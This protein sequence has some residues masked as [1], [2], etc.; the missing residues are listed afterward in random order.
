MLKKNFLAI[1]LVA[2]GI[3]AAF[4][5]AQAEQVDGLVSGLTGGLTIPS[6]GTDAGTLNMFVNPGGLGDALI[7]GYYNAR[8]SW[9]FIRVVN[10]S[11]TL[12]IGAKVRFREGKNSN[13][14]LDFAICLSAGDEWSAWLLDDGNAANPATLYWYDSDTPS[15]PDPN[16]DNVVTN[17]F[18]TAIALKYAPNAVSSVTADDTK[19]GYLEII[20]SNAWTD[21]PGTPFIDTPDRCNDVLGINPRKGTGSAYQYETTGNHYDAP[22]VLFG[23]LYI[24]QLSSSYPIGTYAYNA[25]AIANLMRSPMTVS[26]LSDSSPRLDD[27][28][29][30][31]GSGTGIDEVN[32][33]LTKAVEYATYDLETWLTGKTTIINTFPTKKLSL[34]HMRNAAYLATL[35]GDSG[36]FNDL[37]MVCADGTIGTSDGAGVGLEACVT[38]ALTAY[39]PTNERCEEVAITIWDDAEH[40]PSSTT[41]FSPG[42]TSVLKKCDEVTLIVVGATANPVVNSNLVN[43]HLTAPYVL[44]WISEDFTTVAGRYT[45]LRDGAG[46]WTPTN[47]PFVAADGLPVIS[48]ELQNVAGVLSHMLPLRYRTQFSNPR[49]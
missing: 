10:T 41:G 19:E 12:G 13:E 16:G 34:T 28:Y 26:L 5:T 29:D 30:V 9:D 38:P 22:S 35:H 46:A 32:Y 15:A 20:A 45:D 36:P 40:Y 24:F 8:G 23:N 43:I 44:G 37:A 31:N 7:Y 17:N 14:V 1:M 48:Y 27:A 39:D 18:G 33:I 47:T 21:T 4:G 25:T 49:D 3:F 6:D 42:E 11:T 2:I